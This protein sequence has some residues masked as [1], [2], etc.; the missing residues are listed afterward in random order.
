MKKSHST[1]WLLQKIF[2][3]VFIVLLLLTI[4]LMK[5]MEINDYRSTLE[6]F[7]NY[8]N[9]LLMLILFFSIIFHANIGL[10]SIID[11]YLH[12]IAIKKKIVLMKNI[13]LI[14]IL[15]AVTI[16]LSSISINY[17]V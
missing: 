8:W 7:Q 12:N 5:E 11:D 1:E 14:S 10:T 9:S 6:W 17:E 16:S 13:F 2:A 4:F 15:V 3:L